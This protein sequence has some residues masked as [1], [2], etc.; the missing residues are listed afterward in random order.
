MTELEQG[1][2]LSAASP[3]GR[4]ATHTTQKKKVYFHCHLKLRSFAF[5]GEKG[6]TWKQYGAF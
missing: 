1:G 3:T 4:S 6:A 5:A 2:F